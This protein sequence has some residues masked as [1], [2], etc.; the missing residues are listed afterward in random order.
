MIRSRRCLRDFLSR[1]ETI[2]YKVFLVG[3]FTQIIVSNGFS[4]FP[5]EETGH[6]PQAATE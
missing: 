1:T 5:V 3:C 6:G 2:V 4:G